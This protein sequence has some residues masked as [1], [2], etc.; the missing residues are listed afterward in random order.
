[1]KKL[2]RGNNVMLLQPYGTWNGKLVALD[3]GHG[4]NTPGKRTPYIEQINRVI[5]EN[6]FNS[7]VVNIMAEQ[8]RRNGYRVLLVAPTG[9]DTP[10]K[11]RTDLA[12]K[13]KADIYVSIHYNAFDGKFDGEGKDPEGISVHIYPGTR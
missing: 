4:E 12:N 5:K 3:D 8:L 2:R 13:H 10:L 1:T 9:Y 6:E 7:A 11:Q